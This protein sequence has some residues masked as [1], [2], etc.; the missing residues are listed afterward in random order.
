[1]R[2]KI[3]ALF[4]IVLML[5]YAG[6]GLIANGTHECKK[7]QQRPEMHCEKTMQK[8]DCCPVEQQAGNCNCPDMDNNTDVPGETTAV[9]VFNP[10]INP[11]DFIALHYLRL[12]PHIKIN[13]DFFSDFLCP[14]IKNSKIYITKHSF[15]I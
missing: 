2:T 7:E 15:L 12:K 1:M 10:P 8:M 4:S 14:P 13:K 3:S 6:S 9:L 5:F 11:G